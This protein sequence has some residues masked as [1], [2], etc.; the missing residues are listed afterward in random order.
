MQY[1]YFCCRDVGE[2][3]NQFVRYYGKENVLRAE[4]Q[5]EFEDICD[6]DDEY[7][8]V[9]LDTFLFRDL[10]TCEEN[11]YKIRPLESRFEYIVFVGSDIMELNEKLKKLNHK[12]LKV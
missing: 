3:F 6:N 11:L 12:Y 5:E 10:L 2:I 8:A 7:T 4:T 9:V 1:R